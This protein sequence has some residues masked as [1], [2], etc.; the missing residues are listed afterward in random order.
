MKAGRTW[1]IAPDE[2][3]LKQRWRVLVKSGR[4]KRKEL[5]KDSP[6]GRKAHQTARQLPPS[7]TELKAIDILA[8]ESNPPDIIRFSYRS[9]DRQ[10]IFADARLL[11]RAGPGT[12]ARP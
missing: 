12:V 8:K 7:E 1:V 11:D 5:F 4:D 9:F 2:E 6:T 3:S 10:F